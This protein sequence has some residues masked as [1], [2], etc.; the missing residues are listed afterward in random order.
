MQHAILENKQNHILLQ[1]LKNLRLSLSSFSLEQFVVTSLEM[2]MYLE[3]DEYTD[4]KP[5]VLEFLKYN[6]EQINDLVLTLYRKGLT[7]RDVSDI[8]KNF[9]GEEISYAQVSNLAERFNEL[10]LSWEKASLENH[11]KVAY[12]DAIYITAR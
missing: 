6:Q 2:L 8:L 10:S 5:F 11:Y 1:G 9:F 7:T 4:F 3:R 12:A